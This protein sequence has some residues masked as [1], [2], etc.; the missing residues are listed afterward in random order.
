M[1][2]IQDDWRLDIPDTAIPATKKLIQDCLA[3]HYGDRPSF[4][5]ILEQLKAIE[6]QLMEGVN[7]RKIAL[8]VAKIETWD[9]SSS[10]LGPDRASQMMATVDGSFFD[11]RPRRLVHL[12]L[13]IGRLIEE[14][15]Q[16]NHDP[17]GV[18]ALASA[19]ESEFMG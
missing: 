5:D 4:E 19:N 6:F 9:F 14:P 13:G 3:V 7:S 10:I 12:F 11:E 17:D 18:P 8:F 16:N 15:N 1:A 2:L